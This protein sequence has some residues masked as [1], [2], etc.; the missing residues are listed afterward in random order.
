MTIAA[1]G[2]V[3][4]LMQECDVLIPNVSALPLLVFNMVVSHLIVTSRHMCFNV[5]TFCIL[6]PRS[7]VHM[8][9]SM[10]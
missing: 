4:Q 3:E 7:S 1:H 2:D 6:L 9:G 5:I 10:G 8:S